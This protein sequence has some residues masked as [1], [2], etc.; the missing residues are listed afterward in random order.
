MGLVRP[1]TNTPHYIVKSMLT[2]CHVRRSASTEKEM[3][4]NRKCFISED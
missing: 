4:F 2:R 3:K 1:M